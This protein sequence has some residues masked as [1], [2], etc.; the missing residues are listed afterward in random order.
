MKN[1]LVLGAG[2]MGSAFTVPCVDNNNNV[3]LVGTQ[4]QH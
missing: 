3:I 4:Q 2:A 1:I